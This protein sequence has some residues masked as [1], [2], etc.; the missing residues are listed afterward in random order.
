M[1]SLKH[2]LAD[3]L[4]HKQLF[5]YGV[6]LTIG[7]PLPAWVGS[8]FVRPVVDPQRNRHAPAL[9]VADRVSDVVASEHFSA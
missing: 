3:G 9:I 2:L 7:G 8:S 6:L 1:M 5:A 4:L